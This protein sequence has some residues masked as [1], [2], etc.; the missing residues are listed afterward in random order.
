MIQRIQTL[1]LFLAALMCAGLFY[2]DIYRSGLETI[3][4]NDHYPSL[5]LAIVITALPLVSI[6]MYKNRTRQRNMVLIS[7]LLTIG[8]IA[9]VLMRVTNLND[10]SS[11]PADGTYWIGSVLP[12]IAVVFLVLAI[13]GIRKDN[14]LVK[15]L[16]RLR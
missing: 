5:L 14:K 2:F 3:R 9:L 11:A 1:W 15:S 13:R 8:F 7:M 12:V 6:F 4:V 10:G 16:D